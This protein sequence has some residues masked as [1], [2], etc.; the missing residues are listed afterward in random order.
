M[1]LL[2]RGQDGIGTCRRVFPT[3]PAATGPVP[4]RTTDMA[5]RDDLYAVVDKESKDDA[6]RRESRVLVDAL[7]NRREQIDGASQIPAKDAKLSEQILGE[8]RKRSAQISAS[9]QASISQAL[10]PPSRPIPWWLWLA[11]ILAIAGVVVAF[12]YLG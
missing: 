8:A 6:E 2:S 10:N 11:W 3:L 4:P 9:R 1:S 7:R 12:M 5:S